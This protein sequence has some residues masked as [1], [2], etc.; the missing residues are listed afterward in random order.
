M[1]QKHSFCVF[2]V[3][4]EDI[5]GVFPR[6]K[7]SPSATERWMDEFA[8]F[9]ERAVYQECSLTKN[10]FKTMI[11]LKARTKLEEA[12]LDVLNT[13]GLHGWSVLSIT[14]GDETKQ[15]VAVKSD[16][17]F[18]DLWASFKEEFGQGDE[19]QDDDEQDDDEQG[20]EEQGDD[21]DEV[22]VKTRGKL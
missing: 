2:S 5:V 19:E 20:D 10:K 21:D 13:V 15:I 1:T 17:D 4:A 11:H 18:G 3:S 9:V 12:M 7:G 16:I 14:G 6:M 22:I 8:G